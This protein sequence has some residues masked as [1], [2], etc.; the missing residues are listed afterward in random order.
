MGSPISGVIAEVVLQR[1]EKEVLLRCPPKFWARYVD[2]T[3]V[4]IERNKVGMIWGQLNSLFPYIPFT[5][6]LEQDNQK[7]FVDVLV[8]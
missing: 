2:D 1:L 7:A 3:F 4:V 5:R 6:E 8:T